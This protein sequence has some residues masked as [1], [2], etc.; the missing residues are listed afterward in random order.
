MVVTREIPPPQWRRVLDDLSRVH[1]GADVRL[2]VLDEDHGLQAHGQAFR[3]AGLTSDGRPGFES[4]SAI[5]A[6]TT[7]VTHTIDRP[8]S[9]HVERRWESRTATVQI[10]DRNGTRTLIALG[11]PVMPVARATSEALPPPGSAAD[12]CVRPSN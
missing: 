9:L 7:H 11:P 4:I 8:I 3:L 6:G 10:V 2:E 12:S 1:D 5:L